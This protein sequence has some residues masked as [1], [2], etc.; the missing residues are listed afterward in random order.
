MGVGWIKSR[1]QERLEPRTRPFLRSNAMDPDIGF[2]EPESDLPLGSSYVNIEK[3]EWYKTEVD[4][5]W[6]TSGW[7]LKEGA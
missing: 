4:I 3:Q 1:F 2:K 5:V 6:K 7:C